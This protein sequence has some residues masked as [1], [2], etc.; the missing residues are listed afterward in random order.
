M[1]Q[2]HKPA[3]ESLPI[4]LTGAFLVTSGADEYHNGGAGRYGDGDLNFND[5]DY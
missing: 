4:V 3:A 1:K 5:F 2:Y